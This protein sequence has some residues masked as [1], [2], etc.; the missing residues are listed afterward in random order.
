[1]VITQ[2]IDTW[3]D[4]LNRLRDISYQHSPERREF[5]LKRIE[6]HQRHMTGH[7]R[8]DPYLHFEQWSE[9]DY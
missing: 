6:G 3:N 5:A 7:S 2:I 1:M 8:Y 4:I 9:T